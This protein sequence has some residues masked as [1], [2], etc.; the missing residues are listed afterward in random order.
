MHALALSLGPADGALLSF[1][2]VSPSP[3]SQAGWLAGCL[4]L[5]NDA[6]AGGRA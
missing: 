6:D 5:S 2:K 4:L 1:A 3:C